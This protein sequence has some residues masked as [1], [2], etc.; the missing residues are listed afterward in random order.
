MNYIFQFRRQR[1]IYEMTYHGVILILHF[2]LKFLPEAS[3]EYPIIPVFGNL[4]PKTY[5]DY[6]V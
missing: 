2:D 1:F 3:V 5:K 4:P 6:Y